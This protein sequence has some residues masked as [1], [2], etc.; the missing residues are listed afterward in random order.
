MY[1]FRCDNEKKNLK[2]RTTD[3]GYRVLP[4]TMDTH[5]HIRILTHT[6][7]VIALQNLYQEKLPDNVAKT[8]KI[9]KREKKTRKN[10]SYTIQMAWTLYHQT[11]SN[12]MHMHI[13]M[14][15]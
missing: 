11:E 2:K 4:M 15:I 10:G 8:E 14:M 13:Y 1:G 5:M 3:T 12:I 6:Q 9:Y 7:T